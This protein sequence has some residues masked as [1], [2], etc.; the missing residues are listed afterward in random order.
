VILAG[1]A[2]VGGGS[3]R[4]QDDPA[5]A[6]GIEFL[7][8]HAG[9]QQVG[10]S[11]MIALAML[12]AEVPTD[13][14]T[15]RECV[16]RIRARFSSGG[17]SPERQGGHDIYEAAVVAMML[18]NLES[19]ARRSELSQAAHF[20]TS[21]QNANG[22]WDYPGRTAG[23]TSI[24]QYAVLGLWEADNGGAKISPRVWDRAAQWFLSVQNGGGSWNYHRDEASFPE[25]ISM[26]AAGVG[27]LLI[28]KR[29]LD[30]YRRSSAEN[31]PLLTS[32]APEGREAPYE[33][34]TS[35]ATIDQAVRRGMSWLAG[36][37]TTQSDPVIGPS[38]Y[39]GLYGIERIGA[40]ADKAML[41]RV[42]W[43]EEGRRF[44]HASQR[45]DGAWTSTHGDEL[46][47][48]WAILFLTRSTAKSIR[49]VTIKRLGAGTLLGGRGLPQ[50]LSSMTVAGGRV[51]SRP[52]NGAVEGMLE[53][54]EDPRAQQA[55]AA[56]AGLVARYEAEG[57]SVL[58]PYKD[59]F[60]KLLANRDPGLRRA[61]AWALGR[62]GDLDA[63]PA[64][65][66]GL[67]DPDEEV[68]AAAR[69]GLQLIS[70]KIDGLG[71]PSPS[72]PAQRA[73]AARKWRAW[74]ETTRPLELQGQGDAD[75]RAASRPGSA[76]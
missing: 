19:E 56:L 3:A 50:D 4:A 66:D 18:S 14:P 45:A 13:D 37:F 36:S 2:A 34:K 44:I 67:T 10:E 64:L 51:V 76:R 28:C 12:K 57:P 7:R 38:V 21:R 15:V 32:L 27:S 5:V 42:N 58:R 22:S 23:D 71:P 11:A 41:S 6:R 53:V 73:E 61:A 35:N 33:P 63:V 60:R 9:N 49:R 48:V 31:S 16:A 54:L 40:L 20:L 59:R 26:T 24:S 52:M 25:T 43:L 17:Y 29:Q 70:R 69:L 8:A 68:V 62:T 55:D 47:T 39:Y 30:R 74:Y 72:T 75:A 65:I 1:V 46:N